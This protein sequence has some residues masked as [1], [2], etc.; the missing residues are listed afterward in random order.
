[1][2][3]LVLKAAGAVASVCVLLMLMSAQGRAQGEE[4]QCLSLAEVQG[5]YPRY[6]IVNG[7]HCWYASTRGPQRAPADTKA[8]PTDTDVNPYD[9]P[10]WQEPHAANVQPIAVRARNCEEQ[11]LKLDVKE[12]RAFM[13]QCMSN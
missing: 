3:C 1:M 12:K 13:K 11:A 10:I 5:G 4:S 2:N 7:R 9:D 6:H 8:K